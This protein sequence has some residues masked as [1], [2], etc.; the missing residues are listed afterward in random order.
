MKSKLGKL[1]HKFQHS[2]INDNPIITD[3]ELFEYF[4]RMLEVVSFMEDTCNQTMAYAF[5]LEMNQIDR[6]IRTRLP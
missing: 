5:N 4:E 2:G 3:D 6:V 1:R